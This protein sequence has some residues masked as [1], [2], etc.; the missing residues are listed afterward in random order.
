[1]TSEQDLLN[2][3]VVLGVI[4]LI[5]VFIVVFNR[6]ER[7]RVTPADAGDPPTDLPGLWPTQIRTRYL[8]LDTHGRRRW[9]RR[10]NLT[11][12]LIVVPL[13]LGGAIIG[14]AWNNIVAVVAIAALIFLAMLFAVSGR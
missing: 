1:V 13:F 8:K 5:L 2:I 11:T 14:L 9:W 6:S 10:Y 12:G 3:L 7:R 4:L